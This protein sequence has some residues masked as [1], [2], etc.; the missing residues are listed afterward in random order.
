GSRPAGTGGA[1]G[2]GW[3]VAG[4]VVADCPV[5]LSRATGA[6]CG[7]ARDGRRTRSGLPAASAFGSAARAGGA[8]PSASAQRNGMANRMPRDKASGVPI[9]GSQ[10]LRC[11][12]EC[13]FTAATGYAW[14]LALLALA[15]TGGYCDLVALLRLL[16]D[17]DSLGCRG[18]RAARG[19]GRRRQPHLCFQL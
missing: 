1:G 18:K 15:A 9:K 5:E 10:R 4:T 6:V 8:V 11:R 16:F 19:L 2:V 3:V 14:L 17:L 7:R 13:R 12:R